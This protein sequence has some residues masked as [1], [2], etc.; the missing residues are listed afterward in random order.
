MVFSVFLILL[1]VL[2]LFSFSK[3]KL[4]NLAASNVKNIGIEPMTSCTKASAPS[5]LIPHDGPKWTRTT[6]LTLIR[7]ALTTTEL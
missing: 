3:Y 7:R 6:D 4:A 1:E 2:I 5:E